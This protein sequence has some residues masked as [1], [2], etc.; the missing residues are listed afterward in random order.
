MYSSLLHTIDPANCNELKEPNE[1]E[2]KSDRELVHHLK[3][4]HSVAQDKWNTHH[5]HGTTYNGCKEK[6]SKSSI[7]YGGLVHA[8]AILLG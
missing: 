4:V 8:V 7:L 2:G 6:K 1:Q 3:Q 5:K